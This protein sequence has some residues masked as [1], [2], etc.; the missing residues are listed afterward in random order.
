MYALYAWGNFIDEV[1][2]DELPD[3]LDPAVLRG[4]RTDLGDSLT[5]LD[6]GNLQVDGPGTWFRVDDEL[7]LGRDLLGRDLSG[8]DWHVAHIRV[9]TDGTMEDALRIVATIEEENDFDLE[10]DGWA[11][12]LPEGE[13]VRGWEDAHGQWDLALVKL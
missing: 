3:W 9:K 6:T 1:H 7:V 2:L 8:A 12:L 13:C 4:E 5:I 11:D 10:E